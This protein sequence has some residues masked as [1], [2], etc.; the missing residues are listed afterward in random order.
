MATG[1]ATDRLSIDGNEGN[2][3]ITANAGTEAVMAMTLVGGVGN[4]MLTG[5]VA[6]LN[7]DEGDDTLVV[8]PGI[9]PLMVLLVTTRSLATEAPTN[10]GGGAGSSIG[11]TLLFTGTSGADVVRLS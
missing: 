7:G 5:N 6:S 3:R 8:A 11:D 1:E 10:V 9:K 4:D 2:D